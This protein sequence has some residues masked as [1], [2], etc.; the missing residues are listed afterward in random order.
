MNAILALLLSAAVVTL[1]VSEDDPTESLS[2]VYDL[3]KLHSDSAVFAVNAHHTMLPSYRYA[4][5]A[6]FRD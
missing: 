1:V 4:A 6:H 2:G 5:A 3:S